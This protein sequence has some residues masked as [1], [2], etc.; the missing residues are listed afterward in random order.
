MKK[1]GWSGNVIG[2]LGKSYAGHHF[3]PE[4]YEHEEE[5]LFTGAQDKEMS[6]GGAINGRGNNKFIFLC[7]FCCVLFNFYYYYYYLICRLFRGG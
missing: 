2:K 5:L 4:A 1:R 7:F 3:T 6:G